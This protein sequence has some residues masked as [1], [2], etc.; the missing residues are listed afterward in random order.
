M[1]GATEALAHLEAEQIDQD[2]NRTF[3]FIHTYIHTCINT[4][5]HTYIHIYFSTI[6]ICLQGE[7]KWLI[8]FHSILTG[9]SVEEE[10]AC[11]ERTKDSW[12]CHKERAISAPPRAMA[13]IES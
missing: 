1:G 8:K 4:Y 12:I 7:V 11:T 9:P 10:V 13:L 5:V 2:L 3:K 6:C